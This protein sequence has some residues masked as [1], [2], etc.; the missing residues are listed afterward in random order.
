MRGMKPVPATAVAAL[1][2]SAV[3]GAQA[4]QWTAQEKPIEER[5][6]ML[7]EMPDSARARETAALA[8]RI[9]ALMGAAH[10]VDL[11]QYLASRA[12]EG[13]FGRDTLQEVTTTLAEA[14]GESK[15]ASA[16]RAL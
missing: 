7:R 4:I 14:I 5:I 15:S 1:V 8:L 11:A 6:A 9:R 2:L 12:T 3:L 13:D 16:A 10:K